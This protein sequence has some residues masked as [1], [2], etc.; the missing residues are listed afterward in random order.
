MSVIDVPAQTVFDLY[1]RHGIPFVMVFAAMESKHAI[2]N[3]IELVEIAVSRGWNRV[4]AE[5]HIRDAWRDAYPTNR[6]A[7]HEWC[8]QEE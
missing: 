8:T 5:T 2:C 1:D 7:F 3:L 6:E 4:R